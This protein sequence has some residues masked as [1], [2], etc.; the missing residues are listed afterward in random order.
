[1]SYDFSRLA[2]LV[3]EPS[4]LM[5]ELMRD[6]LRE[7]NIREVTEVSKPEVAYELLGKRGYDL[8]FVDWSM[9]CDGLAL[10]KRI[11]QDKKSPAPLI[12][13]IVMSAFTER[14]Q[15]SAARD[16]GANAFLAKPVSAQDIYDHLVAVV[17]STGAFIRAAQYTGPDRRHGR[18]KDFAGIDRRQSHIAKS[19]AAAGDKTASPNTGA[20]S[21]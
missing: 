7:F 10:L 17:E 19:A 4:V 21:K 1:M 12:P 3:V 6:V 16:A 9:E 14:G 15:V 8:L 5:R 13:V 20:V 18:K 2:I 11:R